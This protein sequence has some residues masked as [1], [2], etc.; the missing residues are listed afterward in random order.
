MSGA[1]NRSSLDGDPIF[2]PSLVISSLVRCYGE[3]ILGPGV[4]WMSPT[5]EAAG[6]VNDG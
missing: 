6:G 1:L 3:E 2:D 4:R 5:N